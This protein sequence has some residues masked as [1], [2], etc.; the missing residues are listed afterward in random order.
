MTVLAP[1]QWELLDISTES[2]THGVNI[3]GVGSGEVRGGDWDTSP[4]P[5]ANSY[6]VKS[7]VE[8]WTRG[9]S[10]EDLGVY[11]HLLRR[12]Q[13]AG[14]PVDG[15]STRAEVVARFRH[16]VR[17][18]EGHQARALTWQTRTLPVPDHGHQISGTS[19]AITVRFPDDR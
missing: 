13:L 17:L 19:T 2:I 6:L 9:T 16:G 10:W 3:R 5:V 1:R 12:I 7:A 15:C 14:R 11:E 18:S 8:H 4:R